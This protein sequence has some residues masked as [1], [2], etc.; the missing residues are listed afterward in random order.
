MPPFLVGKE[1]SEYAKARPD[2]NPRALGCF[3]MSQSSGSRDTEYPRCNAES[4]GIS[5]R[6][7]G[8]LSERNVLGAKGLAELGTAENGFPPSQ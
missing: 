4:F 2:A 5:K 8:D 3:K 7:S 1:G 6:V